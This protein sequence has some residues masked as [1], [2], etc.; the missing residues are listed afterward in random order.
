MGQ[1]IQSNFHTFADMADA[2]DHGFYEWDEL[3]QHFPSCQAPD[4]AQPKG[5][6][7]NLKVCAFCKL[8]DC[9]KTY[10]PKRADRAEIAKGLAG[11][12][13]A[14]TTHHWLTDNPKDTLQKLLKCIADGTITK[15]EQKSL[16]NWGY[17]FMRLPQHVQRITDTPHWYSFH[18]H[19]FTVGKKGQVNLYSIQHDPGN[20]RY[21]HMAKEVWQLDLTPWPGQNPNEV[22]IGDIVETALSLKCL[23]SHLPTAIGLLNAD[24]VL[25]LSEHWAKDI[26][27]DIDEEEKQAQQ[28][29]K[30]LAEVDYGTPQGTEEEGPSP[31]KEEPAQQGRTKRAKPTA[32]PRWDLGQAPTIEADN[33][34]LVCA[35]QARARQ[36]LAYW[37]HIKEEFEASHQEPHDSESKVRDILDLFHGEEPSEVSS[38]TKS[39]DQWQDKFFPIV[40]REG[41]GTLPTLGIEVIPDQVAFINWACEQDATIERDTPGETMTDAQWVA[42]RRDFIGPAKN[43]G[44]KTAFEGTKFFW[45]PLGHLDKVAATYGHKSDIPR[46]A[47]VAWL[48]QQL[49]VDEQSM[50]T[51][52]GTFQVLSLKLGG[53]DY[54][55]WRANQ[56]MDWFRHNSSEAYQNQRQEQRSKWTG[57]VHASA[58]HQW[59][60]SQDHAGKGQDADAWANW[61]SQQHYKG[62][63][64]NPSR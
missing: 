33:Y 21:S 29:A 55:F 51:D 2:K 50:I 5:K 34:P 61:S 23:L 48:S 40:V 7:N 36:E 54:W 10:T 26:L 45:H 41:D 47:A 52:Q 32:M 9:D 62:R 12:A 58:K 46:R 27:F 18:T 44:R 19:T 31:D 6:C 49:Y 57:P 59:T 1:E 53:K 17:I 64:W 11:L 43:L 35:L 25:A 4:L 8:A 60:G 15:Q 28:E 39:V 20:S 63:N 56:T 30:A 22:S 42:A 37:T 24:R 14:Q 3:N 13:R 16:K 38:G